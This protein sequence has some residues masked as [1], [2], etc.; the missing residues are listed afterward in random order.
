M[1]FTRDANR[2]IGIN[3]FM[4]GPTDYESVDIKRSIPKYSLPKSKRMS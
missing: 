3:K 1:S 2:G 4:P